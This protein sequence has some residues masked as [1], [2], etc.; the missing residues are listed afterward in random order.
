MSILT[1]LLILIIAGLI[2]WAVRSV[3]YAPNM[4]IDDPF[5]KIIWVVCVVLISLF[6]LQSIFGI[7]PGVPKLKL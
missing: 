2:L 3:L 5:R 1:V 7:L 6:V 4:A